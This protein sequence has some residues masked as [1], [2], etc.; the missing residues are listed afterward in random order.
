MAFDRR[1]SARPMDLENLFRKIKTKEFSGAAMA[2]QEYFS[3]A[4]YENKNGSIESAIVYYCLAI[5][6][7]GEHVDS[8]NN[9]TNIYI[10]RGN[11]ELAA[12]IMARLVQID[13]KYTEKYFSILLHLRRY[14]L[15][16]KLY[17][18]NID[19]I[20]LT[21]KLKYIIAFCLA[22]SHQTEIAVPLLIGLEDTD[23]VL[24]LR[25]RIAYLDG[26]VMASLAYLNNLEKPDGNA[27]LVKASI[28]LA[29][30]DKNEARSCL[31][32]ATEFSEEKYIANFVLSR[33]VHGKKEKSNVKKIAISALGMSSLSAQNNAAANFALFNVLDKDREYEKASGHLRAA[34]KTA[35]ENAFFNYESHSKNIEEIIQLD[36]VESD[37][38]AYKAN[39]GLIHILGLPR[40][41]SSVLEQLIS[42]NF[43]AYPCGELNVFGKAILAGTRSN[44]S[45][46][47]N[48]IMSQTSDSFII[49]KQP[50]NYFHYGHGCRLFENYK[51]IHIFKSRKEMA[52]SLYKQWFTSEALNWVYRWDDILT[53]IRSYEKLMA[54][55][56]SKYPENILDINYFD[57]VTET[58]A[59]LLKIEEFLQI[60]RR[61]GGSKPINYLKKTAS[62]V[63]LST[64]VD[65]QYLNGAETYMK[66]FPELEEF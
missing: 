65:I 37:L 21:K 27:L 54:Y 61:G 15:V 47:Y 56:R 53:Y 8:Y 18:K 9:L 58:D 6:A 11:L 2:A 49:D 5:S 35:S 3:L 34:N 14:M 7:D 22:E 46:C 38:S 26:D 19:K 42:E 30:G 16:S 41:G 64:G 29:T 31:E 43:K 50:L 66:F 23:A 63:Q 39:K 17:K 25:A 51:A 33:I 1:V 13:K 20:E 10:K 44:M 60:D 40:V 4:Y 48:D 52:W 57:L 59:Q 55:W 28:F 36:S 45:E 62:N 12:S 24:K 32:S